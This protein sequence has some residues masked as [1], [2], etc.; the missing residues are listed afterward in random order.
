MK[1]RDRKLNKL[2]YGISFFK[3]HII[4]LINFSRLIALINFKDTKYFDTI[5]DIFLVKSL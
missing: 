5:Y 4:T 3:F 1:I 2:N